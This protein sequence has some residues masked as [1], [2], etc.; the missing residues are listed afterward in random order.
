MVQV[1]VVINWKGLSQITEVCSQI[2][3]AMEERKFLSVDSNQTGF[4]RPFP[5]SGYCPRGKGLSVSRCNGKRLFA[6]ATKEA[7]KFKLTFKLGV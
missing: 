7:K 5:R 2:Y 6:N 1:L 4:L 3:S